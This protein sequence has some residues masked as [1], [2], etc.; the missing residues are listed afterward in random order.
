LEDPAIVLE[1]LNR[2]YQTLWV[3]DTVEERDADTA[4]ALA[5]AGQVPD[6]VA[7]FWAASWRALWAIAAGEL[8]ELDR[9][10]SRATKLANDVG[11]PIL[12]WTA[13]F[14][15]CWFAL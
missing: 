11:Q 3:V 5:L 12:R 13:A 14:C 2:R 10:L 9:C 7:A 1:V 6:P 4:E 8:G 15:G